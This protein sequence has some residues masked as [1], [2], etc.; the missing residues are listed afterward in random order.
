[1][2]IR[3]EDWITIRNLKRRNP[4]LGSRKI[5]E[6]LGISRNTVKSALAMETAPTYSRQW[7]TNPAI[8][9]FSEFIKESYLV[10]KH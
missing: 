10:K 2:V 7:Q 8:E 5:A 4:R 6:F 1:M 3:V 9:T